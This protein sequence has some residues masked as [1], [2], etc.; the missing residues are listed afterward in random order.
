MD[1]RLHVVF[2]KDY[3]DKIVNALEKENFTV[4]NKDFQ[5]ETFYHWAS[6]EDS[7]YSPTALII[8]PLDDDI[9]FE[10]KA[11]EYVRYLTDVKINKPNMRL[12]INLPSQFKHMKNMQRNF[13][14]LG[15]YDFYFEDN[16]SVQTILKWI[17]H[18]R[19]LADV[20][21][22]I[23]HESVGEVKEDEKQTNEETVQ[24]DNFQQFEE[25][26]LEELEEQEN[27]LGSFI[28]QKFGDKVKTIKRFAD[29]FSI[30][31]N[32]PKKAR[33]R[34]VEKYVTM[35]QQSI[36]FISLSRGAGS[37]F[38]SLN[39]ASYLR[40]KGM[41]VGLYEQP[42]HLDGR[43]YFSDVFE[44]FKSEKRLQTSVPHMIIER[45]PI[46][47]EDTPTYSDIS[48]YATDYSQGY[49]EDFK[50]EQ[51]VRYL[52]VGKHTIKIM[53]FGFVPSHWFNNES[54]IDVL[55]TFQYLVIVVDLLPTNF[56][57]NFERFEFFQNF[58][59]EQSHQ[60]ELCFLINRYDSYVPKKELKQLELD[61]AHRCP[62]IESKL[63]FK[64]LFDK[65]IPFDTNGEIEEKLAITYKGLTGEMGFQG[66]VQ[67]KKRRVLSS[68][69]EKVGL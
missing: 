27:G 42:V 34:V 12:I 7:E 44:L 17:D 58:R 25:E 31:V 52:N 28:N 64:A 36:A 49:I 30:N 67:Y 33:T 19:T 38:H 24:S 32:L 9:P 63:I 68:M 10:A 23:V 13:V 54:F 16:F 47:L 5:L 66:E 35:I 29:S 41:S 2:P 39:Y 57:P 51:F 6:S 69:L 65:K 20:K 14:S 48:V 26:I 45:K 18:K 61:K 55:N 8:D 11:E 3:M 53:D 43:S 21:G 1:K 50:S 60:S 22:L 15:I 46:F 37:T 56:V 62:A 4:T 59:A 40:D